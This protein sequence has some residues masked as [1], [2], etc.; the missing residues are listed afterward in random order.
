MRTLLSLAVIGFVSLLASPEYAAAGQCRG[1]AKVKICKDGKTIEVALPA[2]AQMI[3]SGKAEMG[4]CDAGERVPVC[5]RTRH[6]DMTRWLRPARADR[7]VGWGIA[8][9][10]ECEE[11]PDPCSLDSD[12]DGVA[13]CDDACP[14]TSGEADLAGCDCS[15]RGDCDSDGDGVPDGDDA[16]PGTAGEPD[17]FGCDC[18]QRD[19]DSDGVVDCG[20]TCPGTVGNPDAFGCD[21]SQRGDCDSDGDGV[22]D[23]ED[24]C[25]DDLGDGP[26]GCPIPVTL[27]AHAGPDRSALPGDIVEVIGSAEVLTG[28][29]PESALVYEWEQVSG[30]SVEYE[31]SSP[32][33]TVWTDGS[34][35]EATFRLTVSTPDG[36]AEATDEFTVFVDLDATV[37]DHASCDP[38]TGHCYALALKPNGSRDLQW[39]DDA[40]AIANSTYFQGMRGHL[41]TVTSAAER[42]F[43]SSVA[44]NAPAMLGGTDRGEEGVWMWADGPE[45]G[46]PIEYLPWAAN[47]PSAETHWTYPEG[48]ED[49]LQHEGRGLNDINGARWYYIEFEPGW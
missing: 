39:W 7:L 33:L 37:I 28:D 38:A 17:A 11:S 31:F 46:Q 9:Y 3:A 18:S 19:S 48:D 40:K 1:R 32:P 45:D 27:A 6:G 26:D 29:F 8:E 43:L 10:G 21:C 13:D 15:Q 12:S 2:A 30:N 24:V 47:E 23:G 5:Q 41:A 36:S 34:G 42:S 20:D 35:P 14:D 4:E 25:P 22:P 44:G 16:C 49:Y